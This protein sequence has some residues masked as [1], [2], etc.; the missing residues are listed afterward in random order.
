[1]CSILRGDDPP[2][3]PG[4]TDPQE[5]AV[6]IRLLAPAAAGV[7]LIG[8]VAGPAVA[9][10]ATVA[11]PA[12]GSATS[13]LT[14]LSL[15]LAGHD[16]RVGNVALTSDT[17]TGTPAAKVVVTPVRADGTAYGE[18]TVTPADSP[19]S[20][21]S[22]DST[23]TLPAALAAVA[24]IKSPVFD[25]SSTTGSGA[26]SKAG[27]ASLGSVKVLG[28]PVALNG[29]IDV[30][31]LVNDTKAVGDKTLTVKNLALPSIADL[32]GALGLNLQ[33]LPIKTLTDLLAGLSLTD[34]AVTAAKQ[35]LDAAQALI[36]TQLTAAQKA[37]DDQ[38][39]VVTAASKDLADKTAALSKAKLDLT[40]A[41]A[42]VTTAQTAATAATGGVTAAQSNLNTALAAVTAAAGVIPLS[43]F[44]AAN[45]TLA[46]VQTYVAA[47]DAL[48]AANATAATAATNLTSA[49]TAAAAA[50]ALVTAL[51]AAVDAAQA[52]L[53][54]ANALLTTLLNTLKGLLGQLG[55][56]VTN[57]LA[58]VTAVLSTTPL[59]SIDSFTV[60]T[61]ALATSAVAG[62]QSASVVGG[63]LQGVH[64]LGTDVLSNVLGNT[65]IDLLD[66]VGGTLAQ[67]TGKI[68]ALNG[69][70][71]SV[72]SAVP[73][74]SI[75]APQVAL[76]TKSASTDIVDG[77]GTAQTSV[78]ALQVTIPA[79]TLPAALALPGAAS[80]PAITGA[81]NLKGALGIN[82]VGDLLSKPITLGLGTL[83]EQ[84]KFRPA[85]TAAPST[86]PVTVGPPE[87][88]RTGLPAGIAVL[89][90]LLVGSAL[91][92]RRRLTS[93]V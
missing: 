15:A 53:T 46:V 1:M 89:G 33:A 74:L 3:D 7:L 47:Q 20:V 31:S 86:T 36:Q 67:V 5:P 43:T 9:T 14:L 60:Q 4:G 41:Q 90:L 27:A 92:L 39:L 59:V 26:S 11:R 55:P 66:L 8:A 45:P 38:Q 21:P 62:G 52:L 13:A 61:R 71:S 79:I 78:R 65:K 68:A 82:A 70:L 51:N 10:S 24:S 87:L 91:V 18:Q 34:P 83:S 57:L 42:A 77:F 48:T 22:F 19:A 63:E 49:Q 29:T 64:V 6:R 76:L 75:P 44:I 25:V 56:Q 72:L 17:L 37:V 80:L 40:A 23:A 30:S 81:P 32:L 85:V 35:A 28:L 69:V 73:G 12:A 93:Q 58:A 16:V 50:Q 54:A 2:G 84:A 88:P